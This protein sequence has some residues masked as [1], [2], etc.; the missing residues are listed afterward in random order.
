MHHQYSKG[1]K[2]KQKNYWRYQQQAM[3]K[4]LGKKQTMSIVWPRP[5]VKPSENRSFLTSTRN[6]SLKIQNWA[7]MDSTI[8]RALLFCIG[9]KYHFL[10]QTDY[11]IAVMRWNGGYEMSDERFSL[12]L[13]PPKKH[14]NDQRRNLPCQLKKN[15]WEQNWECPN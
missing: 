4:K 9:I 10:F 12:I 8:R 7:I 13:G 14:T 5:T 2:Q 6:F 11:Y 3:Q 15:G 1:G